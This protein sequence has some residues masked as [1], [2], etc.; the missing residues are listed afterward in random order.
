MLHPSFSVLV[1]PFRLATYSPNGFDLSYCHRRRSIVDPGTRSQD[2]GR[3]NPMSEIFP[4]F[5][6]Y[7]RSHRFGTISGTKIFW[8]S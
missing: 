5:L 8:D 2:T 1:V 3:Q 6:P 4:R 7:G